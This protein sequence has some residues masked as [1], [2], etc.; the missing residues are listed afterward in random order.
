MASS[1]LCEVIV[2]KSRRGVPI[3]KRGVVSSNQVD[4]GRC[5]LKSNKL[6]KSTIKKVITNKET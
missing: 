6:L 4:F 5:P 3:A 1:V 2:S